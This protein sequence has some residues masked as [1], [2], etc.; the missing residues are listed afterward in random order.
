MSVVTGWEHGLAGREVPPR[1]V[2]P[3]ALR[4]GARADRLEQV[5]EQCRE[6]RRRRAAMLCGRAGPAL[7]IA[8]GEHDLAETFGDRA[9]LGVRGTELLEHRRRDLRRGRTI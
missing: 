1:P 4:G 7:G 6:R 2:E 5:G 8:G 9:E 3:E